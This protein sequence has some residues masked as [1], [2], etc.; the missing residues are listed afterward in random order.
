MGFAAHSHFICKKYDNMRWMRIAAD[1][2][3]DASSGGMASPARTIN[4]M[5]GT[6]LAVQWLRLCISTAEGSGLIPSSICHVCML[7]HFSRVRLCAILWTTACQAP[8]SMGFSR[9]EYWSGLPFPPGDLSNPWI[10]P[11]SLMSPAL[12][13]DSFSLVLPGKPHMLWDTA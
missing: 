2:R 9:Q 5:T 6:S 12:A 7:S 4:N 8:L 10:K 11:T 1:L 3:K 13:G